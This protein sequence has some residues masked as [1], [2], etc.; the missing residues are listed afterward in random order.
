MCIYIHTYQYICSILLYM[1]CYVYI[2]TWCDH[3]MQRKA[4]AMALSTAVVLPFHLFSLKHKRLVQ[5][6]KKLKFKKKL[7]VKSFSLH[8]S[9][10]DEHLL[11]GVQLPRLLSNW[12]RRT[13]GALCFMHL[14]VRFAAILR[15]LLLFL[16]TNLLAVSFKN[17]QHKNGHW[18][19]ILWK[20]I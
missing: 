16:P 7:I 19:S 15:H 11:I 8:F 17:W 1:F 13:C 4:T 12:K 9:K 10:K 18:K 5:L 3:V 20:M 14:Q 6:Y 2:Y